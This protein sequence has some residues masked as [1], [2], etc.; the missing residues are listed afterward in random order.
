MVDFVLRHGNDLLALESLKGFD[1]S[2]LLSLS[3][4]FCF[5]LSYILLHCCSV[6]GCIHVHVFFSSLSCMCVLCVNLLRQT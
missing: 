6:C 2:R 1:V 3:V 4:N 5:F